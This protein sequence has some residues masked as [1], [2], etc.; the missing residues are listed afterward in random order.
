MGPD[1]ELAG[2]SRLGDGGNAGDL[3]EES[4]DSAGQGA[5]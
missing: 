4:R 5:G 2:W 1:G 3:A